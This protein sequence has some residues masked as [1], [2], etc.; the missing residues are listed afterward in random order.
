MNG[1]T[2]VRSRT[3]T[4]TMP[5]TSAQAHKACE[6]S[7]SGVGEPNNRITKNSSDLLTITLAPFGVKRYPSG[8]MLCF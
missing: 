4:G 1:K 6:Q 8:A 7:F 5:N 3:K 2:A